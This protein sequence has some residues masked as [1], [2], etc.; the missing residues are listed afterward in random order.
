VLA[1]LAKQALSDSALMSVAEAGNSCRP[2]DEHIRNFLL[3]DG[4]LKKPLPH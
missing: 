3:I 1:Y 2:Y 4:A